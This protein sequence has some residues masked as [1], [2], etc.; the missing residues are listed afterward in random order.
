MKLCK[1]V[2]YGNSSNFSLIRPCWCWTVQPFWVKRKP[3]IFICRQSAEANHRL[4]I[5]YK[6]LIKW[7]YFF[8]FRQSAEVNA[9]LMHPCNDSTQ[10]Q[11][12]LGRISLNRWSIYVLV[13]ISCNWWSCCCCGLHVILYNPFIV[14]VFVFHVLFFHLFHSKS[15]FT[16]VISNTTTTQQSWLGKLVS[17]EI[18]NRFKCLLHCTLWYDLDMAKQQ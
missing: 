7:N 5:V 10:P 11:E 9:R 4:S 1:V 16:S 14:V 3:Q 15:W 13:Q 18:T 8:Q 17:V 12:F 2:W 6:N